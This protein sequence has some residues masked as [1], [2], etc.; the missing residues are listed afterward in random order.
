M[1]NLNDMR[2][3][4]FISYRHLEPD[5]FVAH[6]LHKRLEAFSLPRS[7]R[8]KAKSG[9][10]RIERIFRDEEEL[11]LS[12]DL[13]EPISN[14]LKNSE[15]LICI[16]TPR[17]LESKWCMRE[18]ELFLQTHDRDHILVV[19]AEGEPDESFPELLTQG[20]R[21]PLAADTR[22]ET[23]KEIITKINTAVLRISAAMF[24]L[25]Y[26][27]LRQRHREARLKHLMVVGGVI[28]AAVLAFAVFAT[29]ALIK[30]SKQNTE[31]YEQ[32][33][34]ISN[35]KDT[36]SEQYQNLQ[37]KYV[38]KTVESARQLLG[39]GRRDD[40]I[41]ELK[42]VLPDG[43]SKPYNADV[44]RLLNET[45]NVYS[46]NDRLSPVQVYEDDTKIDSFDVSTDGK[47]V[48]LVGDSKARVFDS[49]SNELIIDIESRSEDDDSAFS[50]YFCGS[51][52]VVVIDGENR[53]Y[54]SLRE[55]DASDAITLPDEIDPS[56]ALYQD[57]DEVV[58]IVSGSDS[59]LAIDKTG[60]VRYRV[61]V[62]SIFKK[63]ELYTEGVSF[64]KKLAV[65][66]FTDDKN[67]YVVVFDK[68]TGKPIRHLSETNDY[69]V[70]ATVFGD[71][72]CYVTSENA[73]QRDG[74]KTR[75][76]AVDI[77]S[78]N[79]KWETELYG[80]S[81]QRVSRI[82]DTIYAIGGSS[83]SSLSVSGELL[84]TVYT[85]TVIETTWTEKREGGDAFFYLCSSGDLFSCSEGGSVEGSDRRFQYKP[86]EEV[87]SAKKV[88]DAL[89]YKPSFL[90]YV[91][92]YA[93]EI[94]ENAEK[95]ADDYSEEWYNEDSELRENTDEVLNSVEGI[96]TRGWYD[97]FFSNDKKYLCVFHNA[98]VDIV[99][100]GAKKLIRTLDLKGEECLG[101][102][103]SE[104]SRGYI[105][106]IVSASFILDDDFNIICEADRI[107]GEDE[108]GFI[109]I[110]DDFTYYRVPYTNG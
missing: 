16:C 25:N 68:Y 98:V 14:A 19:L 15:F 30:I 91:V 64:D 46:V 70:A 99:D 66:S 52:G 93:P 105:I 90:D 67:A 94:S 3:D 106:D 34:E 1:N 62:G 104:L 32:N 92:K 56:T 31:I 58:T 11:P 87:D 5:S 10:T 8:D 95:L 33:R 55:Q 82:N 38:E 28:G 71:T 72:L 43:E 29:V 77:R 69:E 89:Y 7:A 63:H 50:A 12:E 18:I 103:Y 107:V 59:L 23:K 100:V 84:S 96:D 27:D 75:A 110:S 37:D 13:S 6:S 48:L 9:Q 36:I 102:H 2:Y 81:V 78:G 47:Y 79:K 74:G 61:D 80:E 22:G 85:E 83:W 44:V 51:T 21:E 101:M 20:G 42:S 49:E 86:T 17:Y 41:S 45:L 26:D 73:E 57:P 4:A 88:G 40:A 24:G 53:N 109:I 60:E 35:Q 39:K 65:A 54:F 76:V 108:N 97:A